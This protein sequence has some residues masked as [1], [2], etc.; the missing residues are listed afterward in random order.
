M[1]NRTTEWPVD[2]PRRTSVTL[3]GEYVEQ[4]FSDRALAR[5]VRAGVLAKPRRGAYVAG[6]AWR[7]LDAR[8][9]HSVRARATL[10][11]ARADVVL[12]H[13]TGLL[14]YDVP[15]W[16]LP[17]DEVHL[18]R[19]DGRIGRADAGVRQHRGLVEAGDVI[20]RNGVAVMSPT[21]LALEV[22]TMS[23]VEQAL[24]VVD[25]LLHRGL[26]TQQDLASR[27]RAMTYWPRSLQTDLVLRLADP[28]IESVGEARA[29][30]LCFSQ[31]LPM[32]ELQ[33]EV[34]DEAGRVVA[35]LDFAWPELGVYMEFDGKVKYERLLRDGQRASDVVIAEKEREDLV[36]R[37]TGWRCIRITWADLARPER[38]AAMVR[39]IL[40]PDL[41]A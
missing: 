9:R 26:T 38:T 3:R 20:G 10:A 16:G 29:F 7:E 5:L 34:R 41:A 23:T 33:H 28:R 30:Y 21:R 25:D 27:Y 37:L 2:D 40:F 8:G 6:D 12:S 11:Q 22:T 17:L 32:P 18:T 14:E 31:G 15:T 19:R 39:R 4:G 35:R 36:R 1:E 13:V 24:V